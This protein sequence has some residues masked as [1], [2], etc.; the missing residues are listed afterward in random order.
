MTP[1]EA[2]ARVELAETRYLQAKEEA[3]TRLND[4]FSAY[5]DAANAGRT[6][7]QLAKPETFTAGYIRKKLRERGVERR[8]GGPKPRP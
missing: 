6:A 7:D 1:E 4:L 3:D 5:V 8:K 2:D